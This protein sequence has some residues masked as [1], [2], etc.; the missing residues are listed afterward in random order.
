M[1]SPTAL[2]HPGWAHVPRR[3]EAHFAV[4]GKAGA[5]ALELPAPIIAGRL[6][7]AA[8]R[9]PDLLAPVLFRFAYF[10]GSVF[11]GGAGVVVVGAIIVG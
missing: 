11:A 5:P 3:L 8:S 6:L 7:S 2:L 4:A 10:L 1:G 9:R